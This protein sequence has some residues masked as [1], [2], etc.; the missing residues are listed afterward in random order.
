ML[1]FPRHVSIPEH[2]GQEVAPGEGILRFLG[3][4]KPRFFAIILSS[5]SFP[6]VRKTAKSVRSS[7]TVPPFAFEGSAE[8]VV[9]ARPQPYLER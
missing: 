7:P 9:F 2:R 4:L 3:L 6:F 8:A 5:Y 1:R